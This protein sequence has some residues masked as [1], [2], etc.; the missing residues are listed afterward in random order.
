MPVKKLDRNG[1]MFAKALQDQVA[2]DE[3]KK[4]DENG[5]KDGKP[6]TADIIDTVISA[7]QDLRKRVE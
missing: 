7:M 6:I 3:L 2:A 4:K 5:E 1:L